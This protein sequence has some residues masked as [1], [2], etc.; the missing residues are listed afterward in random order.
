MA[1]GREE[2]RKAMNDTPHRRIITLVTHWSYFSFFGDVT[3]IF[4]PFLSRSFL[5]SNEVYSLSIISLFLP[6]RFPL[7]VSTSLSPLSLCPFPCFSFTVVAFSF[8]TIEIQ[9]AFPSPFSF[10]TRLLRCRPP[11]LR[12]RRRCLLRYF[13]SRADLYFQ[14]KLLAYFFLFFKFF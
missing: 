14:I 1:G 5:F 12:L 11:L 13:C 9:R 7:S 10:V 8:E 2:E 6:F 3:V 4:F